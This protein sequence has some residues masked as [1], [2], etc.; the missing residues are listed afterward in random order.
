[1]RNVY[2]EIKSFYDEYGDFNLI[3]EQ[4][5]TEGYWREKA[6]QGIDSIKLAEKWQRFELFFRYMIF[7]EIESFYE[8]N[9][10]IYIG[11]FSWQ[12]DCDKDYKITQEVVKVTFED[13]HDFF[14]Y[15]SKKKVLCSLTSII[16]AEQ[17]F[18]KN[19]EF[20]Y[21]E[22]LEEKLILPELLNNQ[23]N[24]SDELAI[25]LNL[26]LEKLLK[27]IGIYYKSEVF[28]EDFNRAINLYAGPFGAQPEEDDEEFWLGFWDY[29]LLD[30]HLKDS[31]LVPLQYFY[32]AKENSLTADERYIIQDLL[33]TKFTIFYVRRICND[34]MLE[35]VNLL[36]EEVFEIPMTE[37]GV[38]DYKK[39]LLYGHVYS[40]GV[41]MLNYITSV[42]VSNNLRKRIS[43]EVLR[44]QALF[45]LQGSDNDLRRFF[46]RHAVLVRHIVD[47][48]VNLSKVNVGVPSLGSDKLLV[49]DDITLDKCLGDELTKLATEYSLSKFAGELLLQM[50]RDYDYLKS[51]KYSERHVEIVAGAI[52]ISF[53]LINGKNTIDRVIFAKRI[54]VSEKEFT[55]A[56]NEVVKVLQLHIFDPR[57]LTEEGFVVSLYAF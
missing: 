37:Y 23:D 47:I 57:Y 46:D 9:E 44:M 38:V 55:F 51:K 25:Q 4:N 50:G 1:M 56:C 31:D 10:D 52:F 28:A 34:Y 22:P 7:L 53:M 41:V 30:Y 6:W 8:L 33:K 32:E 35:C 18:F 42:S 11:Y 3:I 5:I 2:D 14:G 15:L 45:S 20:A 29:F 39:A 54:A 49:P 36:T 27:K 12:E 19:G 43:E 26:L 40:E 24:V 16:K 13:L 17:S 48:L 21:P